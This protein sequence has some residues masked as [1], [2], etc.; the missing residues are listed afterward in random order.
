MRLV[1]ATAV[2]V[3]CV[4]AA[5]GADPG[6]WPLTPD[7]YSSAI[8]AARAHLASS[9]PGPAQF[10]AVAVEKGYQVW[11]DHAAGYRRLVTLTADYRVVSV[12]PRMPLNQRRY[13]RCC[14]R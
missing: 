6:P 7:P 5:R 12:G 11:A 14:G 2:V 9:D 3:A 13:P 10:R 1:V 8:A 4:S